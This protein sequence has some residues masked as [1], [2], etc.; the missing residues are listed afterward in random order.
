MFQADAGQHRDRGGD[1]VGR[2]VASAETRLDHRHLHLL[3]GQ[4]G[5]GG[6][7]QRLELRHLVV[8]L[9]VAVDQRRRP[10]GAADRG[11]ELRLGD[12][13]AVDADP[14]G[15]RLQVRRQ[16]G[17][18]P[19]AVLRQDLRDH[20]RRRGLAVGADHVDRLKT[21]LGVIQRGHQPTHPVQPEP[22]PE[23][24]QRQQVALGLRARHL[25]HPS[26][27]R[28]SAHLRRPPPA[29]A[30]RPPA[31][32]ARRSTARACRARPG[33]PCAGALA[34]NRSLASLPRAR[35]S[36]CR[37]RRS[38]C[39]AWRSR[40]RDRARRRRGSRRRRRGSARPRP[41]SGPSSAASPLS[42]RRASRA[43]CSA[44]CSYPGAASRA[45]STAPALTSAPSRQR[46]S[47]WIAA[48]VRSTAASASSSSSPCAA[49]LIGVAQGGHDPL[50]QQP[51]RSGDQRPDLL[52]L[53]RDDRVRQRDRLGQHVQQRRDQLG[54]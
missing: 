30:A 32:P 43:R 47:A 2:V 10:A 42:D 8:G 41:V 13:V 23:Q 11:P 9:G 44:V 38:G 40:R 19:P 54:L 35:A 17:A 16:V 45:G 29:R 20:P 15:E 6:R 26:A 7:G 3:A 39:A 48:I 50:R 12:V 53:E 37:R 46:R 24:L 22:H 51:L 31:A 4:L 34:T 27:S 28:P 5:V 1:H 14:L 21:S 52:G 18:G 49:R 36:S 33:R 25:A